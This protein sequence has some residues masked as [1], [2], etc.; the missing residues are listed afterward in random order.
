MFRL[1]V[2]IALVAAPGFAESVIATRTIRPQEIIMPE[3]VR[4]D[5]A[6]IPGAY[7]DVYEV[8]GQEARFA[9]YPGRAV[10]RGAIGEP[11]LVDRNQMVELVYEYGGLRIVAEGRSL[12]RGGVGER[13]RVMNTGSRTVLFGKISEDG[14][15]IVS[16]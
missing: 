3:D 13:I 8:V 12:G 6:E 14:T 9:L 2:L 16:K 10:M 15:I 11:A 1:A 7:R 4:L 5:Q